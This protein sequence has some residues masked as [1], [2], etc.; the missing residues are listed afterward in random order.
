MFSWWWSTHIGF[1]AFPELNRLLHLT[2][3]ILEIFLCFFVVCWFFSKLIFWKNSFR[4]TI[5]MSNSLDPDQARR[6]VGPDLG[7]NCSPR[8]SADVTGIHGFKYSRLHGR[9]FWNLI[10][11]SENTIKYL[12]DWLFVYYMYSMHVNKFWIYLCTDW[13]KKRYK[14]NQ[15]FWL[16][17]QQLSSDY[18]KIH[19]QKHSHYHVL[20]ELW[21]L[22][23]GIFK[24]A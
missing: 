20:K 2:H 21:T 13:Q 14:Q 4:N 12:Y 17:K 16:F 23:G 6:F 22:C 1:C 3:C 19:Q 9:D 24:L 7:P 18:V 15:R 11:T 10:F 5:R 8:L